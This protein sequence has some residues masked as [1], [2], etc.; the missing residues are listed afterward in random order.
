MRACAPRAHSFPAELVGEAVPVEGAMQNDRVLERS[1]ET[2]SGEWGRWIASM[3]EWHVFGG[4]TYDPNRRDRVPNSDSARRHVQRWL[5]N[6]VR[7]YGVPVEAAVVALEY[8]KRGWP[9]FHPLLRV[10]GGLRPGQLARLAKAWE[11]DHGN[12]RL[13]PPISVADVTAYAAKYLAKDLNRG[14]VFF[15]PQRGPLSVHQLGLGVADRRAPGHA[16]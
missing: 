3:G 8:H 11:F 9:H 4:L 2:V 14:D 7:K 13:E 16:S 12:A 10:S 15:W 1:A 5:G 6:G